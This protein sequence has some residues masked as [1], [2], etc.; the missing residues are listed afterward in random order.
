[1]F[2]IC[3]IGQCVC[4][5]D[6]C[7]SGQ[8]GGSVRFAFQLCSHYI[9]W[10]IAASLASNKSFLGVLIFVVNGSRS[11]LSWPHSHRSRTPNTPAVLHMHSFFRLSRDL[12]VCVLWKKPTRMSK[13]REREGESWIYWNKFSVCVHG[14]HGLCGFEQRLCISIYNINYTKTTKVERMLFNS[15]SGLP[16]IITLW[17]LASTLLF[18]HLIFGFLFFFL[19]FI[20]QTSP[21]IQIL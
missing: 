18:S 10:I 2:S 20:R 4:V 14:L 12:C 8:F 7:V 1:M 11:C 3:A 9:S 6:H 15:G 19:N 21:D 13:Q 16:F 17:F 5:V